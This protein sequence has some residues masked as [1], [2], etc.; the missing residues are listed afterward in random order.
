MSKQFYFKQFSLAS[1]HS[2]NIKTV[3]FRAIQFIT[4]TQFSSIWPLDWTLSGATTPGQSGPRNDGNEG[5]HR[6]PQNSSIT[7]ASPSDCLV[8]FPGHSLGGI[9]FYRPNRLS[10]WNANRFVVSDDGLKAG[11]YLSKKICIR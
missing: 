1:V 7:G 8:T 3:L 10:H 2:L 4:C 11:D 9:L 6:I 5:V